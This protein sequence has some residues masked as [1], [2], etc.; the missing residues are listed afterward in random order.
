MLPRFGQITLA[1]L[2]QS[3]GEVPAALGSPDVIEHRLVAYHS[4]ED[5]W[6][7]YAAGFYVGYPMRSAG[8][9]VLPLGPLSL[10]SYYGTTNDA[11]SP[12]RF[13]DFVHAWPAIAGGGLLPRTGFG[14]QVTIDRIG[15]GEGPLGYPGWRASL[16]YS[17]TPAP[18]NLAQG[19]FFDPRT[20]RYA[21]RPADAAVDWLNDE[22]HRQT[23]TPSTS[24]RVAIA[25]PRSRI[26]RLTREGDAIRIAIDGTRSDLA[27]DVVVKTVGYVE[28]QET[29]SFAKVFRDDLGRFAMV[30][31]ERPFQQFRALLFGPRGEIYDE[32]RESILHPS[33]RGYSLFG[34]EP[35]LPNEDLVY[36]LATGE[37]DT[38]ECKEWIPTDPSSPKAIELLQSVCAF[39]NGKGGSIYIGVSEQL[40][41]KGTDRPLR[42]WRSRDTR[43]NQNLTALRAE[44]S[45]AI[46]KRVADGV[47]PSVPVEIDWLE[48]AGG[49]YVCRVRVPGSGEVIHSIIA[50]NDIYV[51]RGANNR[52]ARPEELISP[53]ESRRGSLPGLFGH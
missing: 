44:Y 30:P 50:T 31:I 42:T 48:H 24:L 52:K 32:L 11:N 53:R 49:E 33:P 41:V 22:V 29:A 8:A 26:T 46:R 20:E 2:T 36:V 5:L 34:I 4:D 43:A 23:S 37:T 7:V 27:L 28:H 13:R 16:Y 12:D 35:S 15:S 6:T 45:K 40:E 38:V 21:E 1:Q 47:A 18:G 51:R 10:V 19:P 39:G 14:D 3:I 25:D 17:E 9:Q